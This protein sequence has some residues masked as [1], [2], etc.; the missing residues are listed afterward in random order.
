MAGYVNNSGRV[1]GG[2]P[3]LT[4]V[5]LLQQQPNPVYK[6]P[7]APVCGAASPVT[8]N[9]SGT[10]G[11]VIQPL[12]VAVVAT[13]FSMPANG[14]P[15]PGISTGDSTQ[16]LMQAFLETLLTSTIG[17][18]AGTKILRQMAREDKTP[19]WAIPYGRNMCI[20][21]MIGSIVTTLVFFETHDFEA[22]YAL[23]GC[24]LVTFAGAAMIV[25]GNHRS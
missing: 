20:G 4:P 11:I 14:L 6:T 12:A 1:A 8:G 16:D 3:P 23:I 18:F 13:L 17:I 24:D 2:T 9:T 10:P 7:R 25:F 22:T 21:T 5:E 19:H 15:P